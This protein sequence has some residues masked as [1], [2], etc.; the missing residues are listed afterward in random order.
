MSIRVS[1]G[2]DWEKWKMAN[3]IQMV[4]WSNRVLNGVAVGR[5]LVSTVERSVY[6]RRQNWP[7]LA[8][9]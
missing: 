1:V 4:G 2:H 7:L 6:I 9:L 8:L 5:H 3:P